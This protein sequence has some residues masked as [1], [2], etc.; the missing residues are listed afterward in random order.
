MLRVV[1]VGGGVLGLMHAVA[2]VRGVT[3]N[4]ALRG[5]FCSRLLCTRDTIVEPRRVPSA[6]CGYLESGRAP[7]GYA[8]LPGRQAVDVGPGAV[9]SHTGTWHGGDLVVLCTGAAHTGIA[10]SHLAGYDDPPVRR[11]R[12]HMFQTEPRRLRPAVRLRRRR[13]AL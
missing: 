12:L 10:G 5:V 6:L 1:V 2:A 13:G 7:G 11:V 8:W 9:R 4:P 3:V